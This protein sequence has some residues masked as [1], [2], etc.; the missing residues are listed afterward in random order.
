MRST[1]FYLFIFICLTRFIGFVFLPFFLKTSPILLIFLSPFIHHLML[2]STL[3]TAPLFLFSGVAASL[4]QCSIGYEFGKKHGVVGVEWMERHRIATQSQ[5]SFMTRWLRYSATLV[6]FVIPGPIVAMLAGVSRLTPKHFYVVMIPSQ[7]IWIV[8]CFFL[9][10]GL[11]VYLDR[12]KLFVI[13][14]GMAISC[15]LMVIKLM[16]MWL[17]KSKEI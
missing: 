1:I 3:I 12:V 13:E 14:H 11:E 7:I 9:G 2:T 15:V 4:F 16:Q 10:S 17:S 8:A 6:L 5:L